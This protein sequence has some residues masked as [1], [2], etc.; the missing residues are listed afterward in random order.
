MI[1]THPKVGMAVLVGVRVKAKVRALARRD[2][3]SFLAMRTVLGIIA[4]CCGDFP[5]VLE[6]GREGRLR[7]FNL[8][9]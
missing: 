3:H 5:F 2:A 6:A 9:C 1:S 4:L 7:H 8:V